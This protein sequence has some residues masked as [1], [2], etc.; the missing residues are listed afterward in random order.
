MRVTNGNR[1]S[2]PIGR[3][4]MGA[5]EGIRVIDFT[6]GIAGPMA[7]GLL[8]QHGADVI[9]VEGPG[10]DR[11]QG[12]RGYLAWNCNKRRLPL[13][14]ETPQGQEAAQALIAGADVAVFDARPG[15]LERLG[16][17]GPSLTAVHATLI[18]AW[19]PMFGTAGRW[20]Q[21]EPEESLLAAASCS[22][23]AQF[24]WGDEPTHLITPQISYGQ[25]ILAAG[26]IGA[27]IYERG[28]SGRGQAVICTGI[29]G[30]GAVRSGGAIRADGMVRMGLGRGTRG[31]SPNY[32]LYE[33]A[34]GEWLFLGTLTM[35]FFLRALEAMDLLEV[36]AIDGVEGELANMQRPPMSDAV[37]A[38]LEARF[39][40]HP[41]E[42]WLQVLHAN[43]VPAGPV[44]ERQEWFDGGQVRA[45]EM[46]IELEHPELGRVSV[47]G[48]SA[49]LKETPGAVR[50]LMTDST[51]EEALA[52]RMDGWSPP[53]LPVEVAE[54]GPLAGV[55]V[56]D[57]GNVIAGPF[58]PTI[59]ANYGAD[60]IK[61][62][63][64]EGDTFRTAAIGFAGWNRGKRSVVLDM[65]TA[66]GLATF[67]ELVRTSDVV[68]GNFR[69]GVPERLGID[70]ASLAA[71]NPRIICVDV[72]GYGPT[73][74]FASDPGFDPL[75]QARSGLMNA[76]GGEDEPVFHTIPVND[77]ASG[78]MSAFATVTALNA[79]LRTNRGQHVWTSLTNQS[80]V[81][82]SG[83]LTDFAGAPPVPV[84]YR[85]CKG[86]S[87]GHRLYECSDG[88][89]AVA[90]TRREQW[91]ALCEV[92]RRPD[93]ETREGGLSSG[94]ESEVAAEVAAALIRME[95]EEAA[96]KFV[97]AGVPATIA[98]R[99]E[100]AYEDEWLNANRF[101]EEYDLPGHGR[102][103]GVRSYAEFS[104]T[105]GG[106]TLPAPVLGAHTAEVLRE[107][108]EASTV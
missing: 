105:P 13:D 43:G 24:S 64:P 9:K 50:S 76:Q 48:V 29:H 54:G 67:K 81:V 37:I 38:R 44:G 59:L 34:D 78:L 51:L 2:N 16:L 69:L 18:H 94:P 36:L 75:L 28:Q 93:L 56:L 74:P 99:S 60:V 41:R 96:S 32:R 25:A 84:G 83:E 4:D 100:E 15:E 52:A 95:R 104:R 82:Q 5:Y 42:E 6:Q 108:R 89:I 79:R 70:H 46:R 49:K 20:A 33:C 101:L 45:N 47:P 92:I 62:E 65:K 77:E 58:G 21:T 22:A 14:L 53:A 30:Y 26:A 35:P 57:V 103:L 106:F 12:T 86:V 91:A 23:F 7:C 3:F 71:V 40:E 17:D 97:A 19:M 72:L 11:M 31:A 80:V 61:V 90:V 8:A 55:R 102:V 1:G 39:A 27:A 68:V 88:W 98:I 10:G 66:E 63:S 87:A 107:I 73:G 85:N